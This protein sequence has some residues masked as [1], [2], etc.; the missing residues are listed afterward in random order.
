MQILL[1][2]YFDPN[3]PMAA[4]NYDLLDCLLFLFLFFF[5]EAKKCGNVV[6]VGEGCPLFMMLFNVPHPDARFV[7]HS[8]QS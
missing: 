4:F 6:L 7:Q 8:L 3:E 5:V 1:F 2:K